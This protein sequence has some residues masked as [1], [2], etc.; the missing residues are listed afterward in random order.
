MATE[1]TE[2]TLGAGKLLGLFF[3]LAATCGIFFAVGYSLG[4]TTARE[5][6]LA[7]R[8]AETASASQETAAS[9]PSA[10]VRTPAANAPASGGAEAASKPGEPDL[11]F[12][13][14]VKQNGG[15][16]KDDSKLQAPKPAAEPATKNTDVSPSAQ[17]K[18]TR[19]T[20]SIAGPLTA[21]NQAPKPA[22]NAAPGTS[23][24]Q[25]PATAPAGTYVVQIAAVSHEE[26]AAALAGALR[27]KSYTASVVNNPAKDKLFHVV[28]GPYATMQDAEAMKAKLQGEG[29]NPIIK[30]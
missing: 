17:S 11:T 20:A 16:R 3:L 26:D 30:R 7:D 22:D 21:T 19:T 10:S 14:A 24:Q 8:A 6:A 13:N 23:P 29:Y 9:K 12:Y 25:A 2:I 27:K 18:E 28:L 1:E 4:K 15:D 5:Q